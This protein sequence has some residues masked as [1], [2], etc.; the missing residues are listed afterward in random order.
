MFKPAQN[1]PCPSCNSQLPAQDGRCPECQGIAG[2]FVY[3]SRVAAA[4]LA[5]FGG[6]FGLHRF[7]LRQWRALFYLLL[8]WTPLP[9][10]AGIVESVVF[11]A[12]SQKSWNARYNHG[13]W[14]GRESGKTLAIFMAIGIGLLVFA[15]SLVSWL[16]FDMANRFM[17]AQQQQQQVIL[18][19]EHIADATEQYLQTHQQ[20]PETLS[21]LQLDEDIINPAKAFIRFERGKIYLMPAGA[22]TSEVSMVPVVLKDEVLWDCGTPALPKAMLPRQCR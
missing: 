20:R 21:Q 13:I 17:A 4:A 16:P 1:A 22:Q 5:L 3:K 10:L 15:I 8:C 9:W 11:L 14:G 12:T 18:A 6:M 2:S 19:G 7:Y